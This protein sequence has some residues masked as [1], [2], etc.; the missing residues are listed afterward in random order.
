MVEL[1][2]GAAELAGGAAE[3]MTPSAAAAATARRP[4]RGE[5]MLCFTAVPPVIERLGAV[6]GQRT[7]TTTRW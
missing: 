2:G 7:V 3:S 5:W 6:L 1:A 4:D